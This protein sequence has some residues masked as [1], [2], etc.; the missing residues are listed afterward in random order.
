MLV[1]FLPIVI[2]FLWNNVPL[3]I[4]PVSTNIII[5]REATAHGTTTT[6]N[7]CEIAPEDPSYCGHFLGVDEL[8]MG[9]SCAHVVEG[10]EKGRFFSATLV[11]SPF[12]GG[13]V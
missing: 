6:P 2:W 3:A 4:S 8:I 11:E 12:L 9:L 5:Q 7:R 10:E 1:A 13:R